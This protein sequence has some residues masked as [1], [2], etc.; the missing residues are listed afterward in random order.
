MREH[1][2]PGAGEACALWLDRATIAWPPGLGGGG[3]PAFSLVGVPGVALTPAGR[4]EAPADRRAAG[5][6]ALRVTW[7]A[8]PSDGDWRALFRGP[9]VVRAERGGVAVAETGVQLG[10][11]LDDLY[12]GAADQALGVTW[13]DGAPV[14]KLWAPTAS[15][16]TLL[17]WAGSAGSADSADSAGEPARVVPVRDRDGVWTAAGQP[18]WRDAEYL[19]EVTV[20]ADGQTVTQRVTDPYS[21]GLT[22]DSRR[23]VIVDL[24]DPRW[25]PEPWA[26]TP[27]PPPLRTQAAQTIYELHVRDF[28]AIDATC[29]T[30][31]RGTYAAFTAPDSL[32]VAHLRQL[33]AAGITTVHLLPTFDF[34]SVPESRAGDDGGDGA[35]GRDRFNWGYDPWHWLAPEGSY[36]T[37]GA[38]TGGARSAE[39]RAMVG[40]L[41]GMG[42]R[43]VLDQVYNH[44]AAAGPRPPSV[45]DRIVPGYYHRLDARGRLEKSASGA[46][47]AVER[48]MAGKLVV[49]AVVHWAR[50]Y[51]VD[52]FR[53][54]LMGHHPLA[55]LTAV[56]QALDGLTPERDG[57]DGRSL[58][59][60]GEGW[61]FG[62]VADDRLFTQARQA[63]LAGTGI[64]SF[65]DRLRDAVRGG[66]PFDADH[67]LEQGFATGLGTDRNPWTRHGDAALRRELARQ[68][69][70]IRLGLAGNLAAVAVPSPD[71]TG[72]VLGRD[73]RYGGEAAGYAAEPAE[74]VN[75]VDAHDNET[76]YDIGVWKLP[77]DLCVAARV[78]L[79]TLAL[80]TVT[81]GQ[82]VCFWHAGTELLRSK[83]LDRNSY[84]SGDWVNAIDWSLATTPF[85]QG[86][87]PGP[88]NAARW[89]QMR[90]LL[91]APA[92]QPG[93]DD[94]RAASVAALELLRL[95]HSTPLFTLGSAALVRERVWFP[96]GPDLAPGLLAMVIEDSARFATGDLDPAVDALLVVFNPGPRSLTEALPGLAGRAFAL[97]PIQRD[98]ADPVVRDTGWHAPTGTISLPGR[99]VAVLVE[100]PNG[101][102]A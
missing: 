33:A 83:S 98:G 55:N 69:A 42:L 15:E 89:E 86:L 94:R 36:A 56:R 74:C 92:L 78:R 18:G 73:L 77:P 48:T 44:T 57:V 93:P 96:A 20:W 85:G 8:A 58:Y 90:P 95:R 37:A 67:R 6:L 80:A 65:N 66:Q 82:G 16:V 72:T 88:E 46:N 79:N 91:A 24:A 64:G 25:A 97:H 28:S 1:R 5:Y 32:G 31:W 87:P 27:A 101:V 2:L 14:L 35:D 81:L 23:S 41:H 60:Y 43:V 51:H 11:L 12:G 59:V 99:T 7:A 4:V 38:Q 71:G 10:G 50:W 70:L 39:F 45:L 100:R 17:V 75:Y 52:G 68:T 34:S 13:V 61:N 29:P 63:H 53:F 30:D 76:L 102:T 26:A 54:D 40:A 22:V 47:V 19:W 9:L 84:A 3:E 49:D 62:E 21:V